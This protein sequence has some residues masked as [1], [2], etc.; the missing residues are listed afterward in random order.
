VAGRDSTLVVP[1]GWDAHCDAYGN[2]LITRS[3]E[4][5]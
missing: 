4:A 3:G 2:L 1:P 5:A